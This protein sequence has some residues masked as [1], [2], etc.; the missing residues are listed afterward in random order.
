MTSENKARLL[1]A[2]NDFLGK[3]GIP[4]AFLCAISF[5][6]FQSV[7]DDRKQMAAERAFIR[8]ELV[9]MVETVST[10]LDNNTHA[11]EGNTEVMR[12]VIDRLE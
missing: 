1:T 2:A 6:A 4:T 3:V 9:T 8:N 12:R 10:Q 11:L 5:W 7:E